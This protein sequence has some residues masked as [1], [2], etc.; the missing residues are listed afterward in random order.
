MSNHILAQ[1]R[2]FY[3][4]FL[5]KKKNHQKGYLYYQETWTAQPATHSLSETYFDLKVSY[6][7]LCKVADGAVVKGRKEGRHYLSQAKNI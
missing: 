2:I 6:K 4:I 5:K 3:P 7:V 1:S